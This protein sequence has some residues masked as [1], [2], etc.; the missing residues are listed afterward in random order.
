MSRPAF[1]IMCHHGCFASG[2]MVHD[3]VEQ[4]LECLTRGLPERQKNPEVSDRK[5]I[6]LA[7]PGCIAPLMNSKRITKK[8]LKFVASE[9][10]KYFRCFQKFMEK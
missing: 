3:L 6:V 2:K 8:I 9:M 10:L 4:G 7:K 5:G 1:D